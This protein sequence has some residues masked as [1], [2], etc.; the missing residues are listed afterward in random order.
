MDS[1]VLS[2]TII[3]HENPISDFSYVTGDAIGSNGGPII[4]T[5][6][7]QGAIAY[8]WNFGDGAF[9]AEVD[10]IHRFIA[11]SDIKIML[12]AENIYG[13]KD[14]S[15]QILCHNCGELFVP[16]A[17][18]PAFGAGSDLVKIWKPAGY[19]LQS[20][21]AQIFNTYGELLWSS[22]KLELTQPAEGWDGTYEG[23]A[24]PQDVYVW[25]IEAI[26]IYG[27]R[28]KGMLYKD[29]KVPKTIGDVTLIR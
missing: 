16:N 18:A 7:S 28:W 19:G 4:F 27:S 1:L 17:F 23:K 8:S 22:D 25:K 10:P 2:D 26:F 29:T 15:S 13:C 14:T 3:V 21:L 11:T 20:Y 24:M 9:S 6:L 5:N 12:I